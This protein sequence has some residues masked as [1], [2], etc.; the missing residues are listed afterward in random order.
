MA[1]AIVYDQVGG[2]RF[3]EYAEVEIIFCVLYGNI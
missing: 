1:R 3:S 2:G